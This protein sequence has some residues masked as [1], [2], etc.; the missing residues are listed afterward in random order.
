MTRQVKIHGRRL[1]L[2]RVHGYDN[3]WCSDPELTEMIQRKRGQLLR[4][5]RYTPEEVE[6]IDPV[7]SASDDI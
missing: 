5:L 7:Y 6:A 3:A 1:R 2:Y 4:E